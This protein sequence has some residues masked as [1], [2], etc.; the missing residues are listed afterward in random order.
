MDV[1]YVVTRL[2]C[3]A[4]LWWAVR[5]CSVQALARA[6][7]AAVKVTRKVT[8]KQQVAALKTLY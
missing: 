4:A 8:R 6:E 3:C 5:W 7:K 1:Y 2:V